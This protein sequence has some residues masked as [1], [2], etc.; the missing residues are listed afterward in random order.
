MPTPVTEQPSETTPRLE[1]IVT[2]VMNERGIPLEFRH[3]FHNFADFCAFVEKSGLVR[4]SGRRLIGITG[5]SMESLTRFDEIRD[6][7]PPVRVTYYADYLLL[8][9]RLVN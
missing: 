6:T 8:I 2:D 9:L 3:T 5:F 7:L 4:K 1:D